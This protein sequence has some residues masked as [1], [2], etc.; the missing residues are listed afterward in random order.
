MRLT[1]VTLAAG[2]SAIAACGGS[3]D[4]STTTPPPPPTVQIVS[5]SR[6]SALIEPSESVTITA[7]PRDANGNALS[8]KTVSW[9]ANPSTGAVTLAPNG[10]SVTITGSAAGQASVTATVDQ[11]NSTP[12]T[13]T[14]SNNIPTTADVAV[15]SGGDTFTPSQVDLKAG[16]TVTYSWAAGPHNVTFISPPSSVPNSGDQVA[17]YTLPV[18]FTTAGT[19]DYQCTIHA[20]MRGTITVHP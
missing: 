8:G 1:S 9:S 3:S 2:L 10:A 13:V 17:G 16:G 11:V 5:L 18:T 20:G 7:T 6:S 15:G 12:M 4:G 19:Y 14:V